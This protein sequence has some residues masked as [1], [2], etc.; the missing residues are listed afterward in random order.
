MRREFVVFP[1]GYVDEFVGCKVD[2]T[3]K[4]VAG[5]IEKVIE[6]G[7]DGYVNEWVGCEVGAGGKLVAGKS[8][9]KSIAGVMETFLNGLDVR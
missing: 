5:K 3:G 7:A 1:D 9:R 4:L 2:D 6:Y 8:R